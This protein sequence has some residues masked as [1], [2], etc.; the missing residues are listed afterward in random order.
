MSK[1][2]TRAEPTGYPEYG[3]NFETIRSFFDPPLARSTFYDL[4]N[5]G[6]ITPLPGIRGFYKLNDSL[7]RLGLKEVPKPPQDVP[8]RTTEGIIRLAFHLIDPDLFPAPTW[9]SKAE[10]IDGADFHH[11]ELVAAQ[12]STNVAELEHDRLKVN[13]LQGVLD[14]IEIMDRQPAAE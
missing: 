6:K 5:K 8:A 12:H 3:V 1:I 11:A 7:R 13:Y 10:V 2:S 4:V 14:M 9:L